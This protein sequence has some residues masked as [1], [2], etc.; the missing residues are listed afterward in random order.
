[1]AAI[2][3]LPIEDNSYALYQRARYDLDHYDQPNNIDNAIKLLQRAIQLDPQSAASFAAMSE[4]YYEKNRLNADPQWMKMASEYANKAVSLDGYL[5]TGHASLGLVKMQAGDLAGAEKEFGTAAEL[6]PK[7]PTPHEY[8]GG[9]VYPKMNR[10]DDATKE[11][12]LALQ[13]DPKDWRAY[14]NL[15]LNAYRAG[16]Y[17]SAVSQWEQALKLEP[18]SVALLRNLGA[19]YHAV[20]RDDDAIAVLQR[21]LVINP[22]ADA[23][24]NLGT[25]LFYQGKYDQA[26]PAFEKSVSL[27]D[28][29]YDS[30]ASLGDAY[31]WSS[32]QKDKARPAYATA[33]RLVRQEIT[34][35]PNQADLKA[36]LA[37]YLAK[38]GDKQNALAAVQQ[39]QKAQ[40]ADPS[41]LYDVATVYELCG[42]RD[43]ALSSLLA[44]V[45]AGQE[46]GDI[47]NDP[48]LVSLRADPRY[49]L[50]IVSAAAA[51]SGK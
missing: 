27:S 28:N 43:Q 40:I 9:D 10:P 45:K 24:N 23:Y 11:L 3:E 19:A 17:K 49:Q 34:K 4:A 41:V 16:D 44:A 35:N 14:G 51:K 47:S 1:M 38:N 33:I 22:S 48:E 26:V 30:W 6:D 36:D 8:L 42:N 21:A 37:I 12:N 15:G 5:A 39:L 2:Q 31:R 50:E 46:L 20:G 7:N 32:T 18:D 25:I 29:A 13:L